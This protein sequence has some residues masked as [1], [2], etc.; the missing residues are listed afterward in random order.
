[1]I[2]VLAT[3]AFL[4]SAGP[5][6]AEYTD[7]ERAAQLE[8][9]QAIAPAI[10]TFGAAMQAF[11][12]C[13]AKHFG[14]RKEDVATRFGK[15]LAGGVET[16]A[17]VCLLDPQACFEL[18]ET[19]DGAVC[20]D[21]ARAIEEVDGADPSHAVRLFAAACEMGNA[22]GCTNR[23]SYMRAPRNWDPMK[24]KPETA[25]CA[26][27]LFKLACDRDDEWGCTMQGI[28]QSEGEG[29]AVDAATARAALRKSCALAPDFEACTVARS[30][31]STLDD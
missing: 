6:L 11:A 28:V 31:L 7:A 14:T 30:V 21:L 25:A 20:A 2:R 26:F 12:R 13:P 19:N 3:L 22:S 29:T 8:R 15:W 18:C 10:E 5:A 1:M 4:F 17:D 24:D 9:L 16:D 27:D 23:G